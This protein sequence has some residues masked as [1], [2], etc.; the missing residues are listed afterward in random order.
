M[1][2]LGIVVAI[3]TST[4]TANGLLNEAIARG[5]ISDASNLIRTVIAL[6]ILSLIYLF[7]S[8]FKYP[9]KIYSEQENRIKRLEKRLKSKTITTK[10]VKLKPFKELALDGDKAAYAYIE[11]TSNESYDLRNCYANL[12][13][14]KIRYL[15]NEPWTDWLDKIVRNTNALTFPNFNTKKEEVIIRRGG[16]PERINV[17]KMFSQGYPKFMFSDGHE[18]SVPANQIYIEVSL[19][20]DKYQ[21]GEF[22]PVKELTFHGFVKWKSEV[23]TQEGATITSWESG[24]PVIT[25]EPSFGIPNFGVWLVEGES[26]IENVKK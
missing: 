6:L 26:N 14:L 17:V 3:V 24:K 9:P 20:G 13:V 5:Y 11:V 15:D 23:I 8:V 1:A 7:W 4:L 19:N 16:K 25:K 2:L 12:D 18:P 10:K 21:D 22:V